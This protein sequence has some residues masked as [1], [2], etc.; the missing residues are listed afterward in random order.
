VA[1]PFKLRRD[2]V[3]TAPVALAEV[4]LTGRIED[5]VHGYATVTIER[6]C[7]VDGIGLWFEASLAPG[8]QVT[9]PPGTESSWHQVLLPFEEPADLRPGDAAAWIDALNDGALWR[10]GLRAADAERVQSRFRAELRTSGALRRSS[11]AHVPQQTEKVA[12]ARFVLE[13]VDGR[14]SARE[15]CEEVRAHFQDLF[16]SE[17]HARTFVRATLA[18][19]T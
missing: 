2:E 15:L 9:N 11:P 8:V 12:A 13:R 19:V 1:Q 16:V 3:M 4:D 7:P 10:W 5:H 6:A 18:N 17:E 14:H